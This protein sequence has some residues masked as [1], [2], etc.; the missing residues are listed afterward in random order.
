MSFREIR[1]PTRPSDI[2]LWLVLGILMPSRVSL[3]CV[4][5]FALYCSETV[6]GA[7]IRGG[8]FCS[9]QYVFS[10]NLLQSLSCDE[11]W[12]LRNSILNEHGFCF[13]TRKEAEAFNNADCTVDMLRTQPEW[14]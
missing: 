9:D 5:V 13:S 1:F 2:V 4:L 7:C 14:Q 10:R 8:V 12:N 3:I 11:L 6:K